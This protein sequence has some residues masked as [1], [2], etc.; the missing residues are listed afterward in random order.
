VPDEGDA[1]SAPTHEIADLQEAAARFAALTGPT[2]AQSTEA[3]SDLVAREGFQ[4][5]LEVVA[6][7]LATGAPGESADLI[8]RVAAE[9]EPRCTRDR[10]QIGTLVYRA[11]LAVRL[12]RPDLGQ[13]V[14][15]LDQ[16]LEAA[17]AAEGESWEDTEVEELFLQSLASGLAPLAG[18]D[19]AATLH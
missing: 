3:F 4:D 17:V 6:D 12:R 5:R 8:A 2:D 18:L 13:I 1:S 11:G 16:W 9:I 19:V 15:D 10:L 7:A 14:R